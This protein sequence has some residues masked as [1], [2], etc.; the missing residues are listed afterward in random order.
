MT[1]RTTKDVV[2]DQKGLPVGTYKALIT[3]EVDD[4]AGRGIVVEFEGLE[5]P[6]KGKRGKVWYLFDHSNATTA[7]IAEENLAKLANATNNEVPLTLIAKRSAHY[8]TFKGKVLTIEVRQQ[9]KN[10]EYTEIFKYYPEDY[11]PPVAADSEVPF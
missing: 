5:G 9:K 1:I 2:I 10:P 8:S 4:E 11:T 7:V 3:S 6:G